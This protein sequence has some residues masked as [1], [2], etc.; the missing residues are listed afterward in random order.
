VPAIVLALVVTFSADHSATLGLVTFG[1]FAI[2]TGAI[3]GGFALRMPGSTART[4]QFIQAAVGIVAG[5]AALARTSGGL[6]LLIL[7]VSAFAA[8]TGFLELYLGW[9]SRGRERSARDWTFV[10]ALTI[11][12]AIAVLLVPADFRQAFTGPDTVERELTASVIVVGL[13]GA[14]WVIVGLFLVIAGLSLKWAPQSATEIE[15]S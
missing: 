15:A 4:I 3:I 14:Y 13:M 8:L 9:R 7:L 10:G 11:A 2:A 12:L 6:P 1:V 5:V